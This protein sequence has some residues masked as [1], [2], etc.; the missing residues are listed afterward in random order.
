MSTLAILNAHIPIGNTFECA[1]M[2]IEDGRI[3]SLNEPN[4]DASWVID[5]SGLMLF[6]GLVDIHGDAFE[7]Q[8]MP[9]PGVG[10]S[11]ELAL[12]ETDRQLAA[13]GITTAFHA[14]TWSWEPGLR[15]TETVVPLIE[16]IEILRSNLNVDTRIH[17][18]H[19]TYNLDAEPILQQWLEQKRI[20]ILAFNDHMTAVVKDSAKPDKR[21]V[22]VKRTGLSDQQFDMLVRKVQERQNDV[23]PSVERLAASAAQSHVA[24]MSHDDR[25]P[26]ERIWFR[27]RLVNV[28]EFPVTVETAREARKGS[29]HIVFGAPN[30]VRGG[31]HT[32]C[33]DASTMVKL[34]LCDVLA[35]DYYYPSLLQAPFML[36]QRFGQSVAHYWP[37]VSTNPAHIVG[38]HD[39]GYLQPGA[40]ADLVLVGMNQQ[41]P[42]VYA[43]IAK[44][45]IIYLAGQDRV[46]KAA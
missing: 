26:A 23:M 12:Y 33:P 22:M 7:R 10:F 25:T 16:A 31:S 27:N 17:L 44:G 11:H 38:L 6:P 28:A 9:R 39:R 45:K 35:S 20:D 15:G 18:R 46:L 21:S 41:M 30:V 8:I 32:N 13:N 3:R 1:D 2:R 34:G 36:A 14:I 24:A 40:R 29:D 43:T 42:T 5:A 19:E 37:L 4:S